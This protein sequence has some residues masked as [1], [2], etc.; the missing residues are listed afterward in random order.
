MD[1]RGPDRDRKDSVKNSRILRLEA[2]RGASM[3]AVS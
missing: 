2:A 1:G 3:G